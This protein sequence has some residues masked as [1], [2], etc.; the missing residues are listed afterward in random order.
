MS[1]EMDE[2]P[3]KLLWVWSDWSD[4]IKRANWSQQVRNVVVVVV[5]AAVVVVNAMR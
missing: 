4:R 3:L 2:P 5:V 1:I